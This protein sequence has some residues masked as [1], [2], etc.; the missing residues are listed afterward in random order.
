MQISINDELLTIMLL[1]SLPQYENIRC[2]NKSRD[3]LPAPEALKIKITEKSETRKPD[4]QSETR[5]HAMFAG[6][7]QK[8]SRN[9]RKNLQKNKFKK[10]AT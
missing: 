10:C 3:E 9:Q 8:K 6:E 7:N 1:Y 4:M 2:T 5:E